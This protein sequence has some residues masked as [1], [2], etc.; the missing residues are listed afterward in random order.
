MIEENKE[1]YFIGIDV[2]TGSTKAIAINTKGT[3]IADA[4]LYYSSTNA[5]P[6]YSEQ[7]PEMLLNA[8]KDV[9]KK[10]IEEVK[11]GPVSISFSSAMHG[12]IVIDKE[13]KLLTPLITWS[14]TRSDAI[15]EKI[16]NLP[17]AESI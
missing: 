15:A 8:F 11:F 6:G 2:G 10:I 9:I 14:D 17:E 4:Q 7:D 13:N 1:Q 12:V 16:K 3:I 5:Q